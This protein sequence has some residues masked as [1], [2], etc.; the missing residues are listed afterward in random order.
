MK[1]ITILLAT[2]FLLTSSSFAQTTPQQKETK[3]LEAMGGLC[4]GYI[5][6]T[7]ITIGAVADAFVHEMYDKDRAQLLMDEQVS[8]IGAIKKQLQEMLDAKSLKE[9]SDIEYTKE[10]IQIL[11][12]LIQQ[13]QY[14]R[15]I[16]KNRT[17]DLVAKYDKQR[18]LNW[19][20]IAKLLGI[21]DEENE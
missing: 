7:Y 14:V 2:I 16:A 9:T 19:S 13:A 8:M 11:T 4:A 6:N 5:Y 15:D 21:E 20:K 1:R 18:L 12:G 10:V 3:M 17:D